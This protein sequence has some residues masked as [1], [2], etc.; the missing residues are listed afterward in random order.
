MEI[1]NLTKDRKTYTS[2]VYLITGSW[3]AIKDKNTLVD[4][5]RDET[6][7]E[8]IL[9][10]R[11]G[12]GKCPVEQVVLTHS[13]YDHCSMLGRIRELFNPVVFAFSRALSGVDHFIRGGEIIQMGDRT[14]E[15]FHTPGHSSDSVCYY[16]QEDGALF[17]GDTP[18]FLQSA[19]STYE[20]AFIGALERLCRRDVR[21]V[22][23][24]HG[25]P[26]T[27]QCNKKLRISLRL[28][29]EAWKRK[30]S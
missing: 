4:V 29:R 7:I 11:T 2:N 15:V 30:E 10:A 17:S 18:L 13:H 8:K 24:G 14:F 27:E 20:S 19:G 12:L 21:T 6:I 23:P 3:N 25:A 26:L 28:A 16:C 22:Y 9:A 1:V 5:G